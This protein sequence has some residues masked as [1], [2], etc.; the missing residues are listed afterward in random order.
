MKHLLTPN[1][2]ERQP[3]SITPS[4]VVQSDQ[5]MSST[6]SAVELPLRYNDSAS[7]VSLNSTPALKRK[8]KPGLTYDE[9]DLPRDANGKPILT[10]EN[11]VSAGPAFD[12]VVPI[13]I[14]ML[15]I[16]FVAVIGAFLYKK[17]RDFWDRRHYR[18]M[19]FLIDGMYNDS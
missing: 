8:G 10:K 17:G 7:T 5:N 13:V 2:G 18:R 3:S 1:I 19:D 9:D 15:A 14:A 16:P 4:S 6:M 11:L 12:Y